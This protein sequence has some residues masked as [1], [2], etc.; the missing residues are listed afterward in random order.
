MHNDV[1]KP[2]IYFKTRSSFQIFRYIY[3]SYTDIFMI[4]LY[5]FL[6]LTVCKEGWKRFDGHCYRLFST[7]MNW[8]QAQVNFYKDIV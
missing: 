1:F 2:I 8:F 7:E 4:I 3:I 6:T 5:S